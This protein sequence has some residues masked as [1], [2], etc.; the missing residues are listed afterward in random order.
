MNNSTE[1]NTF[2]RQQSNTI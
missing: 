1:S 2:E